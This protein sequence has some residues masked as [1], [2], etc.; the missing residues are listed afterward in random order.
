M[1]KEKQLLQTV[2]KN[3]EHTSF[4]AGFSLSSVEEDGVRRLYVNSVKETGLASKKGLK[5]GD[6]ILEINNRAA[7]T[8]NSSVLKD[9]LTQPSLGLLVRTYPEPEGGVELLDCPPHRADGPVDLSESP[10]AFLSSNP[11]MAATGTVRG[12]L[13]PA[14]TRCVSEMSWFL[15]ACFLLISKVRGNKCL[16]TG[17]PVLHGELLAAR[18]SPYPFATLCLSWKKQPE[19]RLPFEAFLDLAPLLC[20]AKMAA[21]HLLY[22]GDWA[23]CG[24]GVEVRQPFLALTTAS[25]TCQ[26]YLQLSHPSDSEQSHLRVCVLHTDPAYSPSGE[27][28]EC[29]RFSSNSPTC[30]DL[31]P[32]FSVMSLQLKQESPGHWFPNWDGHGLCSEQGSSAETAPEETEGPDLESSDE[33]DHSSKNRSKTHLEQTGSD[34]GKG[35][36][37]PGFRCRNAWWA[38]INENVFKIIS[39]EFG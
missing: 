34:I 18:L 20:A 30:T 4:T 13:G 32:V 26:S 29:G 31:T 24:V 36:P 14:G 16:V 19:C 3:I 1:N 15:D 8:L 2:S 23:K 5:A 9:F 10:L 25:T 21:G 12:V 17:Q 6:E 35:H 33:T 39:G 22:A 7:G 37:V 27:P 38:L 11:G 28:Y